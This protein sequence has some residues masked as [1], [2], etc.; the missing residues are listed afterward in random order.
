MKKAI[1]LVMLSLS[2][3]TWAQNKEIVPPQLT[4][5]KTEK[6]VAVHTR[7]SIHA[8]RLVEDLNALGHDVRKNDTKIID[9]YKLVKVG[10]RY[11][12]LATLHVAQGFDET[13]LRRFKVHVNT[14]YG[15]ILTVNLPTRKY[16][17]FVESDVVDFV[18]ITMPVELDQEEDP[19]FIRGK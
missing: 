4:P 3:G 14:R 13:L 16:V 17:R 19:V 6:D 9:R 11:H 12:V 18:E 8:L 7:L 1:L 15:Q 10:R 5:A 2:L